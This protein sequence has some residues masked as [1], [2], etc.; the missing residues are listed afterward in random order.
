MK[1]LQPLQLL[2]D[3]IA[4]PLI[5]GLL[6]A[7]SPGKAAKPAGGPAARLPSGTIAFSSLA[8][9]GWD[10]YVSDVQTQ[11]S[12][13]LTDHPALDY[14]AAFSP[15]GQGIAFVSE[16]DGNLELYSIRSDGSD[17]RRLTDN[18]ALDDHPAF[19]PD[20]QHLAFVSTRQPAAVPGQAWNAIYCMK[21]DGSGVKRL[22]PA[23]GGG[24]FPAWSPKGDLIAFASGSG[25]AGGTDIF[26]MKSDG[27]DRRLVVKNGGWPSFSGDGQACSSTASGRAN[28]VY[29]GSTW[30]VPI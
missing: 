22:S 1:C 2:R 10:L 17:L 3:M 5:A 7:S 12:R 26:I 9:R 25:K 15:D 8:P 14:N 4:L 6:L 16:R 19:S 30:T 20:G 28:G 24:L 11:K 21:I 23:G 18:F 27:S 29:G 13:R